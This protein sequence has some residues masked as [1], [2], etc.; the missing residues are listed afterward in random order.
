MV[1]ENPKYVMRMSLNVL[2]HLGLNLYSNIPSVL[3][4]VVANAYDAD[5]QNVRITIE[6]K[7]III[8]D[9]GHGMSLPDINEKF[10]VVGYQKREN[11]ESLTPRFKRPVMGRKGIGKLSLFSIANVIEVHSIREVNGGDEKNGLRMSVLEIKRQMNES[12]GI[13]HP[14]DVPN[15]EFEITVG[16][17]IIITDFK[18][19]I[20]HTSAYLRKRLAKR[21][22]ILGTRYNFNVSINNEPIVLE[23][24]DYFKKVEFLWLIGDEEDVY[25]EHYDFEK[26]TKLNGSFDDGSDFSISG[27]IGAVEFPSDLQ[28][29]NVNNNNISI[30]CRGKMAQE[31]ILETYTEGGMYASYLIGEITAD[32]LDVDNED[33]IATSSRQKINE[34]DPRYR[35]LQAHVYKLLKSIQGAW[36]PLRK[37]LKF[38]KAV[39]NAG[40]TDPA[41]KEWYDSLKTDIRKTYARELFSTIESFHFDKSESDYLNKKKDLYVQGI[42]AF[43][44]LKMRDSL[45]EL[46]NI[47]DADDLKLSKIFADLTDLEANLYYDIATGRVEV[48][49]QFQK[50]L[51]DNDKE[52]LLQKYLFDNLWILNPSWERP[53]EGTE[54]MEQR[55]EKEF[56]II[57]DSLTEDERAG[58]LDIKYRTSAG[59]HIIIELKRYNP[60]YKV[61]PENLYAQLKKYRNGLRKC[62]GE[63]QENSKHIESIAIIGQRFNDEDY[64]ETQTLL[65]GINGRLIYYDDLIQ[66]SLQSYSDYLDRQKEIS[67]LRQI[68][69]KIIGD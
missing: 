37:E 29:D 32:F 27:W 46:S 62:L 45:H 1:E 59:K 36:S 25:S 54:I 22:S 2:N 63:T 69:D 4:E 55:V 50:K 28:Q 44:K 7:R 42:I 57:V 64:N 67:K 58:R 56:G 10:L 30:I 53:T 14:D 19:H 39:Q 68:I 38:K 6:D 8:E 47:Q 15:S 18:K 66:E 41:L 49:K 34:E 21:F 31:D 61:T 52:K 12:D 60:S 17:R 65:S 40:D 48:I 24:R 51:D 11:G 26:V 9:D 23:D 33:D 35:K 5:A 16:T 3:S 20:N 13:Y 43:E